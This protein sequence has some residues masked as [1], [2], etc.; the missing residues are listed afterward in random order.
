M[1]TRINISFINTYA[2]PYTLSSCTHMYEQ[3]LH[4][5]AHAWAYVHYTSIYTWIALCWYNAHIHKHIHSL[6]CTCMHHVW[7]TCMAICTHIAVIYLHM[8]TYSCVTNAHAYITFTHFTG[9]DVCIWP[10]THTLSWHAH[11]ATHSTGIGTYVQIVDWHAHMQVCTAM[12][13]HVSTQHTTQRAC[14][15]ACIWLWHMCA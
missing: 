6:T 11:K 13:T 8:N 3:T 4:I 9:T 1:G 2:Q 7:H 12:P 15:C 5:W 10:Y 14:S